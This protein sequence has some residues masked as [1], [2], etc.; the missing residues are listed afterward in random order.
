MSSPRLLLAVGSVAACLV[1]I[2]PVVS[3]GATIGSTPIHV[4]AEG[5]T[6]SA[7]RIAAPGDRA[8]LVVPGG[9]T[10]LT[11]SAAGSPALVSRTRLTVVRGSDLA[12]LFTGSLATFHSLPV[13]SGTMLIVSVQRPAGF[14]GLKAAA[15]LRWS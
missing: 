3:Q 12:T 11:G 7:S 13:T 14:T 6:V 1:G 10:R 15:L 5:M 4:G 9:V 8:T 2:A